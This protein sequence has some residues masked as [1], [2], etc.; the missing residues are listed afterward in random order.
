M[1]LPGCL[2]RNTGAPWLAR[3]WAQPRKLAGESQSPWEITTGGRVGVPVGRTTVT[4]SGSP[5]YG[6]GIVLTRVWIGNGPRPRA[7]WLAGGSFG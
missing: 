7:A 6:S 5:V 3:C 4:S 2:G 1:S